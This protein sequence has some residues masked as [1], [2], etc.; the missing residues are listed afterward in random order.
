MS[1]SSEDAAL[2]NRHNHIVNY[3]LELLDEYLNV[4]SELTGDTADAAFNIDATSEMRRTGALTMVVENESWLTDNFEIGW[5]NRL[6]RFSIGLKNNTQWVWYKLGTMLLSSDTFHYDATTRELQI[7]LV[8]LMAYGTEER[9]SQIGNGVKFPYESN[10]KNMIDAV[11]S[12]WFP[13]K[14]TDIIEF[15]DVLPYDLEFGPGTYPFEVLKTIL[16]L[17]PWYEQYYDADGEYHVRQIPMNVEDDCLLTHEDI[18]DLIIGESRT[19]HYSDL[20]NSTEIIGRTISAHYVATQCT[21]SGDTYTLGFLLS[22]QVTLENNK[23]YSFKP[24]ED[25]PASPKIHIELDDPDAQSTADIVDDDG[26]PLEAGAL[27]AGY[28]YVVRCLDV[29]EEVNGETVLVKKFFYVGLKQIHVIVRE[30]NVPP[31]AED[32]AADK[33]R[34]DCVDIKYII[35]P[36]SP[37]ACDRYNSSQTVPTRMSIQK[38]EIRQV[39]ADGE[40]G[41]IYSTE[42]A[43]QRGAYENYLRCRMNTD[44]ELTTVLIPFIDVNKKIEYTSPI[45]GEV[46][47]YLVKSV[48]MDIGAFTM[49]MKLA[50]FYDYYPTFFEITQQPVDVEGAVDDNVQLT[51]K[52]TGSGLTYQWQ[53]KTVGGSNWGDSRLEGYNT[54]TLTVPVTIA[55]YSM[56]WRCQVHSSTGEI[57]TSRVVHINP[58]YEGPVTITAQPEGVAAAIGETVQLSVTATG[59]LLTYQWQNSKTQETWSNSRLTG[60]NTPTLSVPVTSGRY[61]YYWRCL[62]TDW[63]GNELASDAVQII[64]PT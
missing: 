48:D 26:N 55:R 37:Y 35:N 3:K 32:I 45:T 47:Q 60:Y 46:H 31:S 49:T 56:D 54:D 30:M 16:A 7:S 18:D 2:I 11:I 41:N 58:P 20:K 39:L 36:D 34:N 4:V 23:K 62:I 8:D 52:A 50:R 61:P 10:I 13:Y 44:V 51:L 29:P 5:I 15:P 17:F 38:G 57:L 59:T 21:L 24:E 63:Y 28:T 64:Q 40:Y 1:Y 19:F 25:S 53:Y 12:W 43:Y 27:K 42:L 6:V 14:E 22:N 33:Q 9:G